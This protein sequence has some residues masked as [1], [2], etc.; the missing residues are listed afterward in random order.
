MLAPSRSTGRETI[1]VS[2][3][4]APSE[5]ARASAPPI[6]PNSIGL[7]PRVRHDARVRPADD[8]AADDRGAGTEPYRRRR[9][10][11]AL[12]AR[13]R[14]DDDPADL[15]Q[16]REA[17]APSGVR[18]V[19]GLRVRVEHRDPGDVL[20]ERRAELVEA[21]LDGFDFSEPDRAAQRPGDE[22]RHVGAV[23]EERRAR[24]GDVAQRRDGRHHADADEEREPGQDGEALAEPE[25]G[26]ARSRDVVRHVRFSWGRGRHQF[27][28]LTSTPNVAAPMAAPVAGSTT[29]IETWL[30]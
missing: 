23:R 5:K 24:V 29:V 15:G 28:R 13:I 12:Q 30:W 14:N 1:R 17:G 25:S 21:R 7:R 22:V 20:A 6:S 3:R 27:S 26:A 18:I 10:R 11:I 9:H 2:N 16:Q 4:Y 8:E 19:S